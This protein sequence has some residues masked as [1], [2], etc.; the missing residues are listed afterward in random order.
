MAKLVR[1][2]RVCSHPR[3]LPRAEVG[4]GWFFNRHSIFFRMYIFVTKISQLSRS[5]NFCLL[6]ACILSIICVVGWHAGSALY[7]AIRDR[8]CFIFNLSSNKRFH[9]TQFVISWQFSFY[10]S[11]SFPNS[12]SV[13]II[14]LISTWTNWARYCGIIVAVIHRIIA[15]LIV[16]YSYIY[17]PNY[18]VLSSESRHLNN[19]A[20]LALQ[21]FCS[22]VLRLMLP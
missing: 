16:C 20:S 15:A 14:R 8:K 4:G 12:D 1:M 17:S 13:D 22:P 7:A 18:L 21:I 3:D 5:R 11:F 9:Q 2:M 19:K 6:A 10:A